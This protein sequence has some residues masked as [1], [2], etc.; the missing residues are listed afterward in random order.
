M[1]NLQT[2]RNP[3]KL[4]FHEH[5]DELRDRLI[6]S[7]LAVIILSGLSYVFIDEIF[8]F[9]VKPVGQ[10]V[11]TSPADAFVARII[12]TL[13]IGTVISMPYIFYH[14]WS[15]VAAGLKPQEKRY[16]SFFAPYSVIFFLLGVIFS[17]A[18]VVPISINFLLGFST[19]SIVPMITIKNYISFVA[20]L[21]FA[22]G[23][24]FELPLV[25]M[26]LTKIGIATPEYLSQKRKHAY[27]L[28]TVLSAF[29]TPPDVVTLCLM[30]GPLILHD[31]AENT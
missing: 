9:I 23:L 5:L 21:V 10:L 25:L 11:F 4:S 18:I 6:K 12:I 1:T 17:Y 27:V 16:I 14:I 7:V 20:T 2:I 8:A 15:F 26:F 19:E 30:S 22:F 28:I 24:I 13:V 29:I 31:D 3:N